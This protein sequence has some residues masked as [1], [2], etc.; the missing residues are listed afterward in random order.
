MGQPNQCPIVH[1]VDLGQLKIGTWS[2]Q[3][4]Q[5]KLVAYE[6]FIIVLPFC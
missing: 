6:Q 5:P 3:N 1:I 4:I 2:H